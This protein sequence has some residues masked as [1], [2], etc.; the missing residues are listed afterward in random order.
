MVARREKRV[1]RLAVSGSFRAA[2]NVCI[3]DNEKEFGLLLCGILC[4][5]CLARFYVLSSRVRLETIHCHLEILKHLQQA[6]K[7]FL[8]IQ[9][10]ILN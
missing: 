10:Y 4:D 3:V 1:A 2:L 7:Y 9:I 6:N 8:N 5:I